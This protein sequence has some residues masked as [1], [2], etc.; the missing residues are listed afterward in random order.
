MGSVPSRPGTTSGLER[1]IETLTWAKRGELLG[2]HRHQRKMDPSHWRIPTAFHPG[3]L[4]RLGGGPDTLSGPGD[5][6]DRGP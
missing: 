3:A 6:S 5:Y 4:T 2:S 1:R